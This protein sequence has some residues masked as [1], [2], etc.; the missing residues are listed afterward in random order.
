MPHILTNFAAMD[1]KP[2]SGYEFMPST[3]EHR[4][5]HHAEKV[6]LKEYF[7]R[8]G[9]GEY[10]GFHPSQYAISKALADFEAWAWGLRLWGRECHVRATAAATGLLADLWDEGLVNADGD[11]IP[12]AAVHSQILS[13]REAVSIAFYWANIPS[14][15]K[16]YQIWEKIKS[17]PAAWFETPL[18]EKLQEKAFF[19]G[20]LAADAL[21]HAVFE[22]RDQAGKMAT[23][24]FGGAARALMNTGLSEEDAIVAVRKRVTEELREWMGYKW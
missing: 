7:S 4:P 11:P 24:A 10:E 23:I 12:F 16:A 18:H 3:I 15:K 22:K 13:P 20:A 8:S 5:L 14:E 17:P 21:V 19:W 2:Y 9:E 1:A 6:A